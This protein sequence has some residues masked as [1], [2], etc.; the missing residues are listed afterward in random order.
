M[1]TTAFATV[2]VLC[3]AAAQTTAAET[4]LV[5]DRRPRAEIIIAQEPPRMTRLAARE[6]QTYVEKISGAK[7]RIATEPSNDIPV[8]VYVGRSPHTDR[9]RV[10]ADGLKYGAYRI[11]SRDNW[12]VLIGDDADFTPVEPWPRSNSDW[13]SGRVHKEWDRITGAAWGNPMSQLRKHYSGRAQDFGKPPAE[14]ADRSDAVHVWGFD[15]RGSF[16]AVCGFLRGLGVRW[17]MPGPLGEVV[18]SMASIPL[19]A[20]DRTVR[21]DFAVRRFNFRFGVH[22]RDTAMWAMHLGLRDPYGLQIAHGMHAM[23]HRDEI[24][25]AHP[26]WF[27]LYGGKRHNRRGQ[28][29]NQLCYSNRGLFQ[30]TLRYVR[31]LMD[32]YE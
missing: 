12:L 32:H 5:E 31:A 17:Y 11:V 22:G 24:L 15:E 4:F 28:R 30:E 18:P 9:L 14:R 8:K 23:T 16:N 7:L 20:V 1:K 25:E 3:A 26:E 29:L 19:P 10:S 21:P 6:L 27:A 2:C 13:V